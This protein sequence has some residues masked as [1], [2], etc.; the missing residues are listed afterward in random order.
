MTIGNRIKQAMAAANPPADVK[1]LTK[2]TGLSAST[3]YDLLRGDSKS[4][5]KLHAIA[6][7]LK[8]RAE[9]LETGIGPMRDATLARL[10]SGRVMVVGAEE[11]EAGY[12][13]ELDP[14]I[15]TP[16]HIVQIGVSHVR[17]SGG[18][19]SAV[20][21]YELDEDREPIAYQRAWFIKERLKPDRCKRFRVVGDSQE[22][23]LFAGDWI[24]VNLDETSVD[25]GKMYAFR[26]GDE[27]RVKRLHKRLN[28]GLLLVSE[29]ATQYPPE[30]IAP[31]DVRDH[32]TIIGRVRD[33][34]G[35]GGL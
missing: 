15:E 27:L 13:T 28:G 9:W 24:L 11:P 6:A 31:D 20:A 21:T 4:T 2:A 8:V 7:A 35:K 1:L 16:D 25:N 22:P 30:E 17:F 33:K 34:G 12:I 18:N 10:S 29:N 32:I 26:Y 3:L 14:E 23:F 5:T 19:G